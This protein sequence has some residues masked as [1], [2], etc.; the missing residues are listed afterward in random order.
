MTLPE[1]VG[2]ALAARVAAAL[3]AGFRT[4]HNCA[5]GDRG[6]FNDV[7]G[8]ETGLD[9]DGWRERFG[10]S[11]NYGWSGIGFAAETAAG[12]QEFSRAAFVAWLAEQT[13]ASLAAGGSPFPVTRR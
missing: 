5:I 1:P 4:E 8:L 6:V 11:Y 3:E 9:K 7:V 10:L 12:K 13:D 2:P